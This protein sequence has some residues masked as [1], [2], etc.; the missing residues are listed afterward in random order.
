MQHFVIRN[1]SKNLRN[2]IVT[3][4]NKKITCI[5]LLTLKIKIDHIS[6]STRLIVTKL[7]RLVTTTSKVTW[8][9][10]H[11]TAW[12]HLTNK[13]RFISTL[14]RPMT[15]K[16]GKV[17]N[18]GKGPPP[19]RSTWSIDHVADKKRYISTSVRPMA[20]TLERVVGSNVGL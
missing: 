13:K 10:D 1:M 11:V 16:L 12:S 5:L 17:E 2:W 7:G 18:Y 20:T 9:Y 4:C 15:V 8:P 3:L 19:L 6:T 14:L